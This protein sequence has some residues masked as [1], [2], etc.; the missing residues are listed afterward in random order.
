MRDLYFEDFQAGDRM[1]FGRCEVTRDMIVAFARQFDPQPFHLDEERAKGTFVGRL[2]ASGWHTCALQMR[3]VCDAWLLRSASMGGPGIDELKWLRPVLP[4][5]VLSVRQTVT[6]VR[7]S[8]S[9]PEMGLVQLLLETLNGGGDIAMTQ[10][11]WVMF[12]RRRPLAAPANW[13]GAVSSRATEPEAGPA[14]PRVTEARDFD[15]IEIGQV[16]DLGSH[17]FDADEIR[18]FAHAFDP[19]PFHLDEAAA[20]ASH[21]GGLVAS[22]WHTAGAWMRLLVDHRAAALE[23]C[24]AAGEPAPRFGT[25]PGFRNLRW[26]KPV[27]AG[28][29]L[30]YEIRV[31]DK[32]VSASR[33]GWGIVSS[34][35][36]GVNQHGE[37]AFA[38]DGSVFSER[39]APG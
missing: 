1:E 28:D 9:R 36:T 35:A 18:T 12:E 23:R 15:A 11:M 3:M 6:A 31:I 5:D 34:R 20:R 25:S 24:E 2:I 8:R 7:E 26:G 39:R 30:R 22:G 19:Q 38:M 32:R 27:R 4:G 13:P 29:T 33:P 10:S 16:E 17:R 37:L 14:G 21:F